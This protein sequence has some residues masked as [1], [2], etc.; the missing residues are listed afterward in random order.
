MVEHAARGFSIDLGSVL[1]IKLSEKRRSTLTC[2]LT[3][4]VKVCAA[5]NQRLYKSTT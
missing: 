4:E 1:L 2:G 5:T 3:D